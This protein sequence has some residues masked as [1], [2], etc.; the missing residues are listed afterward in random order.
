VRGVDHQA[1]DYH[2]VVGSGEGRMLSSL[3]SCH[4]E[5]VLIMTHLV[6]L[7]EAHS[8][9]LDNEWIQCWLLACGGDALTSRGG[10]RRVRSIP[11]KVKFQERTRRR[12]PAVSAP[13]KLAGSCAKIGDESIMIKQIIAL[14]QELMRFT[15]TLSRFRALHG[16]LNYPCNKFSL[17]QEVPW[18]NRCG[19]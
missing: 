11:E 10:C 12:R 7:K 9:S 6:D 16:D 1:C 2:D 5:A 4:D 3:S 15:L 13:G 8:W 19:W 14:S 18:A 17:E